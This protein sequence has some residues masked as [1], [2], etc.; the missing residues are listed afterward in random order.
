M[1]KI[2]T[3]K[4]ALVANTAAFAFLLTS[5]GGE[6]GS[7]STGGT[8]SSGGTTITAPGAPTVSSVT[9]GNTFLT[10]AFDA[11]SSN[12]GAAITS[13]EATCTG[14]GATFANASGSS[15]INVTG[16]VNGTEYTCSVTATN[17]AG[18][19]GASNDAVGTPDAAADTNLPAAFS[20]FGNNVTVVFNEA[21]G[22]ITLEATGKP[23]HVSPY[24]DPDGDSELYVAPGPETTPERMSPGFIDEYSIRFN[25]TVP[26][27]P[28]RAAT[29]T[30]TSLG[31]IGI[32]ITGAPIFNDQ[33]GSG[34]VSTG[35]ASG[36]DNYGAHTG[37]QTYHYHMEPTPITN[38][39][40]NLIGILADGFLLYGRHD[41]NTGA[42]PT[43]LDASGGHV[44]PTQF[45]EE[46]HYHY[47]IVDDVYLTVNDKGQ[48]VLFGGDYQGTP[49]AITN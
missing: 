31:A 11:P 44:G 37:P 39:D 13:Y 18:T 20:Q 29:S 40:S 12:G 17:S 33:E 41:W 21:A 2:E 49:A 45:N 5:C 8:S 9:V 35:V 19:S 24:W 22:T 26:I 32:M 38:A 34:D 30:A 14:D 23:D 7:T 16:L 25:L 6:D 3:S 42:P 36:F 27:N 15:P 1:Q 46:P 28:Q 47:H 4:V 48:Y 10:I 43:D